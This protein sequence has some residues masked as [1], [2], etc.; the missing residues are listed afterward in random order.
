MI[1]LIAKVPIE[2]FNKVLVTPQGN[3]FLIKCNAFHFR[4]VGKDGA[5]GHP[6]PPSLPAS[7]P[8]AKFFFHVKSENIKFLDVKNIRDLS[9][10]IE[11][12]I[13]DKK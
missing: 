1:K 13:S 7:F 11:Q 5:E 12:D 10:F 2:M 9:L 8:A 4:A 3:S 6:P